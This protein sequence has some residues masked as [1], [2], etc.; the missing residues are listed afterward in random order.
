MH[1]TAFWIDKNVILGSRV[2]GSS[3]SFDVYTIAN[4]LRSNDKYVIFKLSVR[5]VCRE[6]WQKIGTALF[7]G[8]SEGSVWCSMTSV[9]DSEDYETRADPADCA[10]IATVKSRLVNIVLMVVSLFGW[11]IL[12]LSLLRIFTTGWQP[13]MIVHIFVYGSFVLLAF[14]RKRLAFHTRCMLLLGVLLTIGVTSLFSQGLIGRGLYQLTAIALFTSILVGT[15]S[16]AWVVGITAVLIVAAGWGYCNGW[17]H[18]ALDEAVYARSSISWMIALVTTLLFGGGLVYFYSQVHGIL[19]R[20]LRDLEGR[21]HALSEQNKRLE[22]EIA[23]RRRVEEDLRR[24]EDKFRAMFNNSYEL[25]GLLTPRGLLLAVN[26]RILD[27]CGLVEDDVKG[28]PFWSLPLFDFDPA[29]A[30][31]VQ[32]AVEQAGHGEFVRFEAQAYD[33]QHVHHVIDLSVKPVLD[34]DGRVEYL[35]PEGRDITDMTQ[36]EQRIRQAQK[37]EAI[38]ALAGGIAHDFN[39]ILNAVLGFTDLAYYDA[40]EMPRVRENLEQVIRAGERARQLVRQI[41]DFSR[42]QEGVRRPMQVQPIVKETMQLLVASLPASVEIRRRIDPACPP[43]MADPTRIHQILMNLCTNAFH[44]MEEKGGVLTVALNELDATRP[45]ALTRVP[46]FPADLLRGTYVH[47]SVADTG[48]GMN[49]V[50]RQRI[51]EP[52]FS[53]RKQGSGTGLGLATV[54]SIVKAFDGDVTV[55]SAPGMGTVFHVFLPACQAEVTVELDNADEAVGGSEHILFVDDE[56]PLREWAQAALQ[57]LGYRVT[58]CEN[59]DKALRVFQQEPAIFDLAVVDFSMPR[60]S[61]LDLIHCLHQIRPDFSAILCTGISERPSEEQVE[62]WEL[63]EWVCKPIIG[64]ALA[65]KIRAVLD[66]DLVGC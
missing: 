31:R 58:T 14:W 11:P 50:T 43:V 27:F 19:V 16:A 17:V 12:L 35:I 24:S 8:F 15:R 40:R 21:E 26:Q 32:R 6:K 48:H 62:T 22:Q 63:S 42:Q 46:E 45:D 53:T 13:V 29:L 47:L 3:F 44:A 61:G 65:A 57:R 54:H 30:E 51:F 5:I 20:I 28:K 66:R 18:S 37:M 38:G 52:Y 39:N 25:S 1:G 34:R 41:L 56:A 59:G 55:T 49:E 23:E 36:L 60:M 9:T 64:R 33:C 4:D 2:P 10:D 7:Y